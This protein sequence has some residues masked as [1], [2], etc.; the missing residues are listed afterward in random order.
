MSFTTNGKNQMLDALG[1]ASASLHTAFPGATGASEVSGGSYARQ[2]ATFG[3]AA[4]GVRSLSAAVTFDVPAV[5]VS[6]CGLWATDGVTFQGYAPNGG[7]PKEFQVNTTTDVI[8]CPAHG[9]S[10][11]QTV[12]FYGDTCPN[13]LIEGTVYYVV[14]ATTDTFKVAATSGGAAI[15]LTTA[16]AAACVVSK[17]TQEVYGSPGTHTINTWSLGLPH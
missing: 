17:I 1:V 11:G 3:A 2:T 6:W 9:Y 8:S 14:S 16:G 7:N 10:D 13:P 4:A 12:T 15:D 5:T